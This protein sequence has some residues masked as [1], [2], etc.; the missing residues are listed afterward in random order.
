MDGFKRL[1]TMLLTCSGR[2]LSLFFGDFRPLPGCCK[3]NCLA[4]CRAW[5]ERE[6]NTD[7]ERERTGGEREREQGEIERE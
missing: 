1:V 4:A 5:R 6:E 7:R 2:C 3:S